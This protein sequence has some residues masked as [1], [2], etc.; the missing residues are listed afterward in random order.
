MGQKTHP[1]GF[2]LGYNKGWKSRWFAKRDYADLLHEDVHSAEAAQGPA[3]VRRRRFDRHRAGGQQ[4]GGPDLY[5]AA[6]NHHRP[7]GFGNRQAQGRS[8]EADQARSA[9]RHS[10]S[11]S[12]RTGGAA[13]GGVDCVAAGKARG[14]PPGDAQGGGFGA[15][16]WLQGNQGARGR[17]PERRGN[18]AQGMVPAGAAAAANASRGHR[19]RVGR[20]ADDLRNHRR[21]VLDLSGRKNS[22]A[23]QARDAASA[24]ARKYKET[25]QSL[26]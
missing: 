10:G 20:S 2:R 13:G 14:I 16:I 3:E 9:H 5:R 23:R 21:E 17:T 18:R 24:R 25:G 7:E 11:A 19:L 8:A 22:A 6:G 12:A 26:C 1:Y 15:A 4:A